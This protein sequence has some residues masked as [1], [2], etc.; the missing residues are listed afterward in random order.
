[1]VL[2]DQKYKEAKVPNPVVDSGAL[3][4][5]KGIFGIPSKQSLETRLLCFYRI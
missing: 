4:V 3:A 2:Q 5:P 1:M